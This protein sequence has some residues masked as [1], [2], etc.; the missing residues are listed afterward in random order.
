[1]LK[2]ILKRMVFDNRINNNNNMDKDEL[3]LKKFVEKIYNLCLYK[4]LAE[5]L[6]KNTNNNINNKRNRIFINDKEDEYFQ[7]FYKSLAG[8]TKTLFVKASDSIESIKIKIQ[9]KE[10]IAGAELR[11]IFGGKQLD[12]GLTASDYNIKKEST[13]H[14]LLRLR[15]GSGS[16]SIYIY[17]LIITIFIYKYLT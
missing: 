6:E 9:D 2:F 5:N 13:L 3:E 11:I 14:I 16:K 8:K 15:G 4:D 1:M 12:D 7:I 17:Y 10:G